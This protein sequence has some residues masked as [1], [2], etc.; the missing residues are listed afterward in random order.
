[1]VAD[2]AAPPGAGGT[3]ARGGADEAPP[4][5]PADAA[6]A[7]DPG[8]GAVV[9]ESAAEEAAPSGGAGDAAADVVRAS[10]TVR[11]PLG[12]HARPA[13]VLARSMAGFDARVLVEGANAASVIALMKLGA[14]GGQRLEVQGT[15]PQAREAVD[16][17]VTMVESG[18]GEA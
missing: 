4:G 10:V 11:N 3:A 1:Q 9:T 18:F 12:L 13:A 6:G 8:P 17:F 2:L 15:G 14:T 7:P 5:R 16:A